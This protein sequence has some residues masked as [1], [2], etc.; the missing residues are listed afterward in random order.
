MKTFLLFVIVAVSAICSGCETRRVEAS[1]QI[2]NRGWNYSDYTQTSIYEQWVPGGKRT[3]I[4]G[5][6]NIQYQQWDN[7]PTQYV[8]Q[9]EYV[10]PV[11]P[12]D[13]HWP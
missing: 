10:W 8:P 12:P 4:G 3:S 2:G 6:R 11:V 9:V 1:G 7:G 5:R 13:S